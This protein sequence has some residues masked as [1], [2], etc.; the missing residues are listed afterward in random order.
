M[1]GNK[2]VDE[3]A[4]SYAAIAR[5]LFGLEDSDYLRITRCRGW[6]V[7]DLLF[8]I[9]LDAQRALVAFA[10]PAEGPA[11]VDFVS[12]WR[13]FSS[14]DAGSLS[15]ARFVR[16]SAS[17]YSSPRDI[18]SRWEQ[19]ASAAVHASRIAPVDGFVATQGHVLTVPD[20]IATLIVEAVVHHL[21][22]M[23]DLPRVEGPEAA[24]LRVVRETLDGLLGQPSP[25]QWDD[26][27]YALKATGREPLTEGERLGWGKLADQLPLLS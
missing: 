10:T 5:V 15:H 2:D 20:F 12:Y 9:L 6:A 3:L 8:H 19:T 18:A 27:T 1:Q 14:D 23:V 24:P 16:I 26:A 13:P 4:A 7:C 11:D 25:L 22:L 17:A 21:D